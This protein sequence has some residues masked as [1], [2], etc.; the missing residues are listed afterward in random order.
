VSPQLAGLAG[1]GFAELEAGSMPGRRAPLI[2][3]SQAARLLNR[4]VRQ[5]SVEQL[6]Q[7]PHGKPTANEN[8]HEQ[9]THF[10]PQFGSSSLHPKTLRRSLLP[11][12][13]LSV[14]R[15]RA[16]VNS[17]AERFSWRTLGG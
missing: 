3:L 1:V 14:N 16:L 17:E 7:F 12:L 8:D 10:E 15:G 11:S 5:E 2:V 9:S 6:D 4:N 13:F